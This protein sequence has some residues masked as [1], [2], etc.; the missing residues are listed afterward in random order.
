[1]DQQGQ[2]TWGHPHE[3]RNKMKRGHREGRNVEDILTITSME[4]IAEGQRGEDFRRRM[5]NFS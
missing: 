1:M 3:K 5:T 4:L 2:R